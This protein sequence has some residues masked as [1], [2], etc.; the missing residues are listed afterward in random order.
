[1]LYCLQVTDQEGVPYES[2]GFQSSDD[3]WAAPYD[4]MQSRESGESLSSFGLLLM[5]MKSL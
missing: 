5:E 3:G 4:A 2:C 1:M